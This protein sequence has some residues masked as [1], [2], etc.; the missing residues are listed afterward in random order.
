MI[1]TM[2]FFVGS[3]GIVWL[4][5]SSKNNTMRTILVFKVSLLIGM[6]SPTSGLTQNFPEKIKTSSDSLA[7]GA[8]STRRQTLTAAAL[9]L[10]SAFLLSQ[11]DGANA[12][13]NKISDK[14]DD[15]PKRRGPKP[16]DL[17]VATRTSMEGDDYKGLKECGTAPNCFSSTMAIEEDPDHSIPAFVWS[18][19]IGDDKEKAFEQLKQVIEAY[20][21]GQNGVDGGGFEIQTFEPSKG[22][23]YVQFQALKNGYIDDVE[24]AAIDGLGDRFV[25]VRSS[26]RVGY[27]D[28]G[29]N[30][31][32][33]NFIAQAL[34]SK[35]WNASGV[36][37]DKHRGYATDNQI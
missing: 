6:A 26:S 34:R 36:D 20:Q 35:G 5:D 33:L 19:D 27:L 28:Y 29:V 25:Q 37:F 12:F 21:P 7:K 31:K 22:Y 4:G 15:R 16:S 9:G 23:L 3:F 8:F 32:R 17:G 11:Q 1:V 10:S 14:F 18:K 13:A 2:I 24:F 30:A